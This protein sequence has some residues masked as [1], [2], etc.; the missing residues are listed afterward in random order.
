MTNQSNAA[1]PLDM[2][3][4]PVLAY[5]SEDGTAYITATN[6][7]FETA[8]DDNSTEEPVASVFEQFG[9]V[10]STGDEEPATQ[11]VRGDDVGIYL[12][13]VG[14]HGAYVARIVATGDGTGYLVF[15]ALDE[16]P[17]VA[18]TAGVGDIASVLSHD[19][20]NPLDVAKAHLRAA[21]ETG[22]TEHFDAVASAHDRMSQRIRDVLVLARGDSVV[23]PAED[24][25]IRDAAEDAWQSVET[26]HATLD[27]Q[28]PLPTTTADPDRVR[29]LFEN[30]FRN[31]VEHG[32]AATLSSSEHDSEATAADSPITVTVGALENGFYVADDGKGVPPDDHDVV[33]DPG[34][35]TADGGTGLGLAIVERIVAA[36]DWD[37]TLT[38]AHDGGARFEIRF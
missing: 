17:A 37:V 14:E 32:S 25:S 29:R 12:D 18:E 1:I 35:S 22:E 33:F 19:L 26:T 7:A 21:R 30:V 6:D 28:E 34:Y 5:A 15:T 8:F 3:P 31:S 27:V 23:E 4:D 9:V 2:H 20:R 10:E 38:A 11:L 13:G 24:V 16:Y 36:H